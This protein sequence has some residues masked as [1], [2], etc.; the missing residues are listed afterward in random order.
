MEQK[1]QIKGKLGKTIQVR[2]VSDLKKSQEYYRDVLGC[3][4]DGWGH[5]E[6]DGMIIILQQSNSPEDVRPNAVSKK[7]LDY[8]TDWEG[9]DFGWDTYIHVSW[10]DQDTLVE[11]VRGKGGE[12]AVE[13]FIGAHGNWEFKNACIKDPD[14]YNIV[15]GSMREIQQ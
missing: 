15:L 6:R 3:K 5:A 12:I 13:P 7:R 11:E 2:L 10:D 8:P 4:I 1:Q 14:G 9:P